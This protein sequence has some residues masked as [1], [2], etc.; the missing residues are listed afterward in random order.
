M[1][2]VIAGV[3]ALVTGFLVGLCYPW[4]EA[5]LVLGFLV[6]RYYALIEEVLRGK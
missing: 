5:A 1:I 3:A 6:G 4:I 2:S